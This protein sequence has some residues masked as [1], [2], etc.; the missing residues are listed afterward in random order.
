MAACESMPPTAST[1]GYSYA[2]VKTAFE[3][4]TSAFPPASD[5]FAGVYVIVSASPSENARFVCTFWS[6]SA[7]LTTSVRVTPVD[8]DHPS[9]TP[10]L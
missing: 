9:S 1:P 4:T 6:L 10:P 7:T 5:G 3:I 2:V 8:A